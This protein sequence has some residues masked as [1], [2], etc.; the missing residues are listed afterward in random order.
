MAHF[1]RLILFPFFF[2]LGLNVLY[3]PES[4]SKDRET[5]KPRLKQSVFQQELRMINRYYQRLQGIV[6]ASVGGK[7]RLSQ[8]KAK[9]DF[10]KAKEFFD[11]IGK[12]EER[13]IHPCTWL[14]E[15]HLDAKKNVIK[16]QLQHCRDFVANLQLLR[17]HVGRLS[18]ANTCAVLDR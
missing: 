4:F 6:W 12:R 7:K 10:I 2:T 5:E 8:E 15:P 13:S 9:Q 16:A 14:V 17:P 3:L 1:K 18:Q 11:L